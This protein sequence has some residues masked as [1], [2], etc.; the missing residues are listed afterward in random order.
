MLAD[1]ARAERVLPTARRFHYSNLGLAMLGHL[2]ARLRGGTW[3]Q[4][5]DERVLRP[6]GLTEIGVEPGPDAAIG[7][8]VDAYSDHVRAE[9]RTDF[10]GLGPAAQ[11]WANAADLARWAAF[12]ADPS[13]VDP[14]G[15]V[16]RASTVEEMRWP[17]TVRDEAQWASGFGL[18]LIMVP[19]AGRVVHVGHDGAMPGFI[20]SAYGRYGGADQPAAFSAAAL[21]SSGTGVAIGELVSR[22][23]AIDADEFPPEITPW[24]PGAAAPAELRSALG[25][26]WSEG[27]EFVFSWRNGALQARGAGDPAG[28]PPAI[29]EPIP[30]TTDELRT[31]S[32]REAG[33][34]LRL[35]R[36][37]AT[38]GVT[39]MRWATYLFTRAQETF[40][41]AS[42][43]AP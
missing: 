2:A 20:A 21:G 27:F 16:L 4:V 11:L 43:S 25:R 22:L 31:R 29:F 18:G 41:G 9:P 14:S 26:W 7:Y 24:V 32:G 40:E 33:E 28:L 1:L 13:T 5:L 23:L 3:A 39:T 19:Q 17:L 30:G 6:L 38:G 34:R 35:T 42:P 15:T 8:L 12:L 10:G 37:P 36:D